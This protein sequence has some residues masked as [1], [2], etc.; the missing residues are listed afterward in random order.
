MRFRVQG[1]DRES[2][3]PRSITIDAADE[4]AARH[5][6]QQESIVVERVEPVYL[7]P[8]TARTEAVL[9]SRNT[10]AIRTARHL[11]WGEYAA[12]WAFRLYQYPAIFIGV[13][14]VSNMYEYV[15]A[16]GMGF[17]PAA[18]LVSGFCAA[19]CAHLI[20]LRAT[21]REYGELLTRD[22]A[23]RN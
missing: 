16:P 13:L 7:D 9:A 20:R 22:P 15:E 10:V 19:I 1:L 5:V 17:G 18:L 2:G 21:M 23:K 8:M 4:P 3:V 6:A 14:G 11:D 12:F